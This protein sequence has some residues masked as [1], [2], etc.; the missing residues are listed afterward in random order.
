MSI[1]IGLPGVAGVVR[2]WDFQ[3]DNSVKLLPGVHVIMAM[4]E[5]GDAVGR[6]HL[7]DR[8]IPSFRSRAFDVPSPGA[9]CISP[10][11]LEKRRRG[12]SAS[13]IDGRPAGD[14]MGENELV[15]GPAVFKNALKP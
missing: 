15:F 1:S 3:I 12:N 11:P 2:L 9:V 13:S 10:A 7:V 14:V 4:E 6:H 5:D 8:G